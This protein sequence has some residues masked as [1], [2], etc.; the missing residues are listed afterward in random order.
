MKSVILLGASGSI[1]S[2]TLDI[3][4]KCRDDFVLL[5]FS[6]GHRTRYIDVFLASNTFV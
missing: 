2:Q 3:L 6:L 4:D 1:G 5:G